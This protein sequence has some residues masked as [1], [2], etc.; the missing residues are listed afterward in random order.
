MEDLEDTSEHRITLGY[1][2]DLYAGYLTS[3]RSSSSSINSDNSS[4]SNGD[5]PCNILE[6]WKK[7]RRQRTELEKYFQEPLQPD[8]EF[9]IL[10]W[11]HTKSQD[12]PTLWTMARDILAIPIST[13]TSNSAFC[14]ETMTLDPIFND[15]DPDIIEPLFCGKDWLDNPIRM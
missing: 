10:G 7:L 15:L 13:S 1:M 2:F 9:D 14:I 5:D 3:Q 4:S 6:G 12:S 11:W 8:E